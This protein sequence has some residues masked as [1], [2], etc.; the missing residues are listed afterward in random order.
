VRE[1]DEVADRW[2]A[3]GLGCGELVLGLRA[4][5]GA[6]APGSLFELVATDA[7]VPADLPSWCRMT[8][9]ELVQADPPLFLI[10]TRL[11]EHDP[12]S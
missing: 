7:G 3:G 9:H 5:L 6:L 2:D 4:R 12:R 11:P 8:G 1:I 10:R